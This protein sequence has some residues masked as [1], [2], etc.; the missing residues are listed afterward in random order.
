M[1]YPWSKAK[2]Q[3]LRSVGVIIG[4]ISK[5]FLTFGGASFFARI[6]VVRMGRGESATVQEKG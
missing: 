3:D 1:Q 4:Q 5:L 6:S 2:K